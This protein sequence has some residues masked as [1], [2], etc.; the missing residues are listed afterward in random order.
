[1]I[2]NNSIT[3][4]DSRSCKIW[5]SWYLVQIYS[6]V[7]DLQHVTK[8][9]D[10]NIFNGNSCLILIS[11]LLEASIFFWP[12]VQLTSN[13][14]HSSQPH[15]RNP[16]R[17]KTKISPA[18]LTMVMCCPIACN[19]N[20]NS[21]LVLLLNKFPASCELL[22]VLPALGFCFDYICATS[23]CLLWDLFYFPELWAILSKPCIIS[24]VTKLG[25]KNLG[26]PDYSSI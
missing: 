6:T 5:F 18:F 20:G 26:D 3:S 7:Y 2:K 19:F 14:L 23:I 9:P 8:G 11:N 16:W 10:W 21:C 15:N 12:E 22:R 17:L 13:P 25:R 4:A 1:M 24:P